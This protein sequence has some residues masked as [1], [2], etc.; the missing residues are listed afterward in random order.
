MPVGSLSFLSTRQVKWPI[1]FL[2]LLGTISLPAQDFE[3]QARALVG[4]MTLPEKIDQLHGIHDA[5]HYRYIPPVPRLNIPALHVANGPAGVGPAGDDPQLPAT[6]LPAPIS[7]AASWDEALAHRYGVVIGKES[8]NLAEDLLEGPDIN[9][10][11]VPQ[12][13]RTF[14]AFGEDP[15]LVAR[16][17]V[18]VIQG[19]QSQGIIANVKHYAANNQEINRDYM[20][21]EVDERTLHEI[22]LPAFE[23]AIKEGKVASLM[24][25]YNKV[26][27][28]Y[29]CENGLLLDQILKKDWGFNGFVT[30]D[31]GAVHS[32]VP[33]A[34][35]G[36]D[37]EMP[38]GIYFGT[39]LEAAVN[40]GKVPMSVIDDKLIRR[41]RVM[42]EYGMFDYPKKRTPI[43]AQEDGALARQFAE[44]GMVLLKNRGGLLPLD[45]DRLHTIAII[46]PAAIKAKTG[47][48]GSS[49]VWPLYTV[50]PV[51]GLQKRVGVNVKVEFSDGKDLAQ[52]INLAKS[53]DVVVV[54]VGD[55]AAE[56]SDHPLVL[57][58]NQNQLVK[59]VATANRRTVVVV[60]TGSAVLMPWVD[61]V[62]AILEAWYPGEEDGNAVALV[63]FGDVNPAGKLPLTFPQKLEDLPASTPSQYPG[64][65]Y[66]EHYS[67]GVFVGYR[68]FDARKIKPLFP[69]GYG[70]SYTTFARKNFQVAPRQFSA[71]DSRAIAVAV[72]LDVVNTG[73]RS[74]SDVVEVY[75][76]FPSTAAVPQ[77]PEQ[78]KAFAKVALQPNQTQHVK[79]MLNRRAFS[80]WDTIKHAWTVLPGTYKIMVG[81]SSRD[82]DWRGKVTIH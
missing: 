21:V 50:A 15:Y 39:N 43:P 56:G 62:P 63:L 70:L 33:S 77:P 17:G 49:Q 74:G 66:E 26:N 53:A 2:V 69:F 65:G 38:T 29:C 5:T 32:T 35:A 51:A 46:G 31:F 8:R 48:G 52:A 34:L 16:M 82:L 11:R 22:Y 27:G 13:G 60:K 20:N 76:G 80:Y 57:G 41:Y 81:S 3:A 12:N 67:E 37:L 79:L 9:I 4:K 10:A 1:S 78:L 75:I 36:L 55:N 14:E 25:A 64:I 44:Q 59:A 19:I 61:Q 72:D 47:G 68:H 42:M 58:G 30:S 54:M 40:S 23:A 18:N 73:R 45:A 24:G 6:A 71:N 7:L 28:T